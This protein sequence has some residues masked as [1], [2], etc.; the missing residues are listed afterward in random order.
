MATSVKMPHCRNVLV[1]NGYI[2]AVLISSGMD[3]VSS[4]AKILFLTLAACQIDQ[5][6][7]ILSVA[8]GILF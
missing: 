6:D 3:A 1:A 5:I 4:L 8:V 7:D 2:R